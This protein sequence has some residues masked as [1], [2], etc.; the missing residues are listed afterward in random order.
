MSWM[1]GIDIT[2]NT[3]SVKT[4]YMENFLSV[5]NSIPMEVV[6]GTGGWVYKKSLLQGYGALLNYSSNSH[7]HEHY[8]QVKA[9][10]EQVKVGVRVY[11]RPNSNWKKEMPKL[12]TKPTTSMQAHISSLTMIDRVQNATNILLSHMK[13]NKEMLTTGL[14]PGMASDVANILSGI[15]ENVQSCYALMTEGE[16]DGES[17]EL[18]F[19]GE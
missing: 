18:P 10:W 3:D 7:C 16:W 2:D 14:F 4:V 9:L 1:S 17:P 15:I 11:C 13:H 19:E 8:L 6:N 12:V 5:Y